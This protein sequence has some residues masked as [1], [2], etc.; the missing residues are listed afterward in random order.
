M[1]F[2]QKIRLK[3][4]LKI[5]DMCRE[6][7]LTIIIYKSLNSQS[8]L[9]NYL[10]KQEKLFNSEYILDNSYQSEKIMIDRLY[11]NLSLF[12]NKTKRNSSVG[13]RVF[14]ILKFELTPILQYF[15]NKIKLSV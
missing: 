11:N 6:F 1:V 13:Y 15:L 7:Y 9:F 12:L 10:L 4:K 3:L 5:E 14:S 2:K 8:C